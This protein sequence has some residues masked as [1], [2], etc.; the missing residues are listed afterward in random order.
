MTKNFWLLCKEFLQILLLSIVI[1]V[2]VKAFIIDSRTIPSAS[3]YPTIH[4]GDRVLVNRLTYRFG[5]IQT[6]DIIVFSP[7]KALAELNI[8]SD[9]IKRVIGTPGDTVEIRRNEGVYVNGLALTEPYAAALPL[10]NYGPVTVPEDKL[11]VLG[12]NR[13]DSAD[14]HQWSD[15]FLPLGNVKGKAFFLYWPASRLGVLK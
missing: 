1:A 11:F 5:D 8:T 6:G 3:M 10:Y 12:D 9:L 2:A 4:V 15:P 14:S 13:N 7:P